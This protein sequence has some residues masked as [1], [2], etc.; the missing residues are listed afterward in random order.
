VVRFLRLRVGSRNQ[1]LLVIV[2][3]IE[4]EDEDDY[5]SLAKI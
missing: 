3:E 1:I 2:V 5:D 4:D